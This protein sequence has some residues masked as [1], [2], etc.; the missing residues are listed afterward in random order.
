[1]AG[2]PWAT[3]GGSHTGI[4]HVGVRIFY[5]HAFVTP[6]RTFVGSR[7]RDHLR[8]VERHAHGA[9]PVMRRRK[10]ERGQSLVEFSMIITVVML[11]LLGMM[12]FGFVFDHH[13]TLE[14]ATREGARVGSALGNGGGDRGLQHRA[15]AQCRHG[16][17]ADRRSPPARDHLPGLRRRAQPHLRDQDLQVRR[18]RRGHRHVVQHL[19]VQR[20]DGRR[21]PGRE[22]PV[23]RTAG[24]CS[25]SRPEPP[26]G[27]PACATT[28]PRAPI[29]SA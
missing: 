28:T 14:Y 13:L 24:T 16:G 5:D 10:R 17:P 4:D 15:V 20:H 9:D 3:G 23:G 7:Q 27:V 11:L 8:S 22:R 6:L 19:G 12:E 1:M 25:S 18:E 21:G 29:R 2:C 26:A